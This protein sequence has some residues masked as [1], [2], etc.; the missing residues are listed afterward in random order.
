GFFVN[1]LVLRV[2]LPD[3]PGFRELLGRVRGGALSALAHQELP[4]ERLV[5]ELAP[6]RVLGR[7]PLFQVLFT[8]QNTPVGRLDLPGLALEPLA[9]G[10][11]T[12]KF[13]LTLGFQETP[14]GLAGVFI[15]N[16][17]LFDGTTLARF[18]GHLARLLT[19]AVADPGR[20]L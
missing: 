20:R 16:R 3:D 10:S 9:V 6:E 18:A 8:L 19:A 14:E 2:A 5:E 7:T 12:A 1:T 4:F 17:D 11:D 13:D 15:Y